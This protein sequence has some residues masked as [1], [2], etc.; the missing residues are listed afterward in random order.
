[1]EV[2]IKETYVVGGRSTLLRPHRPYKKGHYYREQHDGEWIYVKALTDS[3]VVDGK[4]GY[5]D[6]YRVLT[7]HY[8]SG[9]S[10]NMKW[11]PP[12]VILNSRRPLVGEEEE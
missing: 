11:R 5:K 2:E 8:P 12:F 10:K 9:Y 3:Y 4:Y 6:E 7:E 1:M